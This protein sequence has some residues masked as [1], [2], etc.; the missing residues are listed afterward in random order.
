[1]DRMNSQIA[2]AVSEIVRT[3]WRNSIL[4]ILKSILQDSEMNFAGFGNGFCRIRKWI[5][6]ELEMNFEGVIVAKL[7]LNN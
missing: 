3:R 5:L 2:R 6:K 1:M 4:I 7:D